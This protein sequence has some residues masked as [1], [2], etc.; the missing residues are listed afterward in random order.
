MVGAGP[1]LR[2]FFALELG[3]EAA[4]VAAEWQQRLRALDQD[5]V[6]RW[7]RPEGMHVT[8]RF[9]GDIERGTV[10]PLCR[11]VAGTV[12]AVAPFE[13]GLT[14]LTAFPSRRRPKALAI[15]LGPE[16]PLADLAAAVEAGVV[17]A[18]LAPERRRFRPHLTLG[19]LRG[20]GTLAVDSVPSPP[21][22][23]FRVREAVLFESRLGPGGSRYLPLERLPLGGAPRL[24]PQVPEDV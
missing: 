19:R 10:G 7:V 20:R 24:E 23:T 5:D 14:A 6:V 4:R 1:S 21:R 22:S 2:A 8:L 18:G 11:T 17:T 3:E 12:G 9:L 13:V 15:G 16:A